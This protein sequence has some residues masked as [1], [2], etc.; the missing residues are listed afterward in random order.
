VQIDSAGDLFDGFDK[1]DNFSCGHIWAAGRVAF[2]DSAEVLRTELGGV[3]YGSPG[4]GAIFMHA[5][6][7]ITFDLMAI[8]LENPGRKFVRFRAMAGNTEV[9]SQN[10]RSVFADAWVLID[11]QMRFRRRQIN[12]Y[13]GA[14]PVVIPLTED[15]RFLTLVATDGGNGGTCDCILFGDPS[16]E[17]V[18][19]EA[20][21]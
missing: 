17:F 1:T 5:N 21:P 7:G 4:H 3:E 12:S 16:L 10:G 8:R 19:K 13:N 11:G 20:K 6:K 2:A 15:N 9:D 18:E 14:M